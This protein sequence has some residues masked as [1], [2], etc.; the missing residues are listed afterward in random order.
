MQWIPKFVRPEVPCEYCRSKRL[1]C[2]KYRG[3][4]NC[5]A[6]STLFRECSLASHTN[7]FGALDQ[8][9]LVD[10]LHI[11]DEDVVKEQGTTTGIKPLKSK[12]RSSTSVRADDEPGS[13]KR[14]GIRFPR[15]AVKTLRDWVDAHA[16]NPYPTEDE[17]AELERT[18]DLKPSQIA[19]WLANARRRRKVAEKTRP[20]VCASPSLGPST[21]AIDIPGI[22][23]DK[24]WDELNP[25]ERWRHSPPQNEAA[26]AMDI[27]HAM[28]E[29]KLLPADDMSEAMKLIHNLQ[30][31]RWTITP[32]L[33]RLWA[34][35]RN[36]QATALAC[37]TA[38]QL[39]RPR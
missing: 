34:G 26:N 14:N 35:G 7:E 37:R 21:P 17:K 30:S 24:P 16:D 11:V 2:Y 18:T 1:A 36:V 38:E 15:H 12:G 29:G 6:C 20:K 27:I 19:N 10:T 32:H 4:V 25:F 13:S 22:E 33:H 31:N 3:E 23:A 28:A 39:P 9:Y 5:T 8:N